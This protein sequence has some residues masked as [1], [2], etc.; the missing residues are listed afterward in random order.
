MCVSDVFVCELY[1]DGRCVDYLE[2]GD[3]GPEERVKVFPVWYRVAGLGLETE[4]TAEDVHPQDTAT[5]Q[6]VSLIM[7][8]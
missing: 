8:T 4:L 3:D 5:E 7:S 6:H 2:N 1:P